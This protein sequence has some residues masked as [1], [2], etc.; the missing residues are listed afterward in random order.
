[1]PTQPQ[2]LATWDDTKP[3]ALLVL[4]DGTVLEGVGLGASGRAV[5]EV[6]FN[7]E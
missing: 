4:A 2:T 5:G 1:M 7:T 6:C 3:T